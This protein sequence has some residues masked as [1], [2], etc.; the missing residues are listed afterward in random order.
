ML[1]EESEEIAPEEMKRLSQRGNK[2]QLWVCL[3]VKVK[4][5]A[6]KNNITWEPRMLHPRIKENSKWSNR[7]YQE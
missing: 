3:V 1:L 5:D 4:S 2:A 7:R 6:V